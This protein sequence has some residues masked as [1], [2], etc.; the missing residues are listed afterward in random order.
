MLLQAVDKSTLF[1]LR[2]Q[3]AKG[4]AF[5]RRYGQSETSDHIYDECVS[6]LVENC[7]K[8]RQYTS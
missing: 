7:F 6:Q 3:T 8:V 4:Y 1:Q 5:D 2:G